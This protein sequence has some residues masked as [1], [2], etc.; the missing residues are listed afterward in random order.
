MATNYANHK[1][2]AAIKS[3]LLSVEAIPPAAEVSKLAVELA[4]ICLTELNTA[5]LDS[6]T[7]EN[8]FA[9]STLKVKAR[10]VD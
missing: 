3:H 4:Q 7:V 5:G 6:K 10:G 2:T 1:L 8:L 9:P